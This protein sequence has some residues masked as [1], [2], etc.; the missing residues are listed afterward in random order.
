MLEIGTLLDNKYRILAEVGHG[1]MSTV[2]LALNEKAN[3][4]WAVKEIIRSED[5]QA[6]IKET[7]I[8]KRLDNPHLPSIVD[9][10]TEEDRFFIVMDYVEGVTLRKKLREEGKQTPADV[11]DWM[12]QIC[13]VFTY[14][15][16]QRP[17]IIYRDLKPSNI[18]LRPDGTVVLIDFGAAREYKHA[19]VEDTSWLGTP[20]YAAP[21]QY[22]EEGG[23]TDARTDIYTIGTTMYHL[24]TGRPP[25]LAASRSIREVDPSFSD[26]LDAV[27]LKCTAA[28]KKDRYQ[29]AAQLKDALA[30]YEDLEAVNMKRHKRRVF[31]SVLTAVFSIICFA[32]SFFLSSYADRLTDEDY[33]H[34]LRLAAS[35]TTQETAVGYLRE[36][37]SLSPDEEE[38]YLELLDLYLEDNEFSQAEADQLVEIL[39]YVPASSSTSYETSLKSDREGYDTFAFR[40]GLAYFYYYGSGGKAMSG[41]WFDIAAESEYLSESQVTRASVLAEIAEYYSGLSNVDLAGDSDTSYAVFWEDLTSFLDYDLAGEDNIKTALVTYKEIASQIMTNAT[42]F[43]DSG[44]SEDDMTNALTLIER[45]LSSDMN[46]ND[47]DSSCEELLSELEDDITAARIV[48]TSTYQ[49]AG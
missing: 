40:L 35:S 27:I 42:N 48:I 1:G 28:E 26:G 31:L 24:L 47:M 2:Y 4:Q 6:L 16:N 34:Y 25:Y 20:G 7:E 30:H 45:H 36:A 32:A 5:T 44:V 37:I 9:I 11:V 13:D 15:H 49:E 3:K 23:Q 8:L 22:G 18:M 46:E 21:E 29:S 39:G 41:S 12:M 19:N 33:E 10:I 17:P 14:L 43:K 38:A